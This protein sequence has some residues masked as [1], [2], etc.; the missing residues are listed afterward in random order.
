[1]GS[2]KKRGGARHKNKG[3]DDLVPGGTFVTSNETNTGGRRT[4]PGSLWPCTMDINSNTEVD[5]LPG[6]HHTLHAY[7][8][9][10]RRNKHLRAAEVVYLQRQIVSSPL[11]VACYARH[12]D[13]ESK[14][15][16]FRHRCETKV[17]EVFP[18]CD[19]ILSEES[20]YTIVAPKRSY[21]HFNVIVAL[22]FFLFG[23]SYQ[24][25]LYFIGSQSS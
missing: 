22:I 6:L 2:K 1:M 10:C 21:I 13:V 12:V 5:K 17:N 14:V 25:P 20:K 15:A 23:Y 7:R 16:L 19:A 18:N 4:H 9:V 24:L 8:H 3:P 11:D